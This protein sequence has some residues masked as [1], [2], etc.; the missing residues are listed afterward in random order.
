MSRPE[1]HDDEIVHR[2]LDTDGEE[3]AATIAEVVAD[4]EGTPIT[5]LP[6]VY[7]CIDGMLSNLYSNPPAPEAQMTVEF[8]Y[9]GYRITV[10]QSGTAKFVHVT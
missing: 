9:S 4:L 10:E 2:E 5:E 1:T 8:T 3:T 7:D 6:T